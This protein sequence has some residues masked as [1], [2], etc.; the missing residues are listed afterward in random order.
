MAKCVPNASVVEVCA[1]GDF[2]IDNECAKVYAKKKY[3]KGVSMP[4]CISVNE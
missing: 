1:F 4:V 2:E 3:E